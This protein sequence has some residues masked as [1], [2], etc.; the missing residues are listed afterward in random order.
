MRRRQLFFVFG[1]FHSFSI[2]SRVVD[3]YMYYQ[4]LRP[5]DPTHFLENCHVQYKFLYILNFEQMSDPSYGKFCG[6]TLSH[7]E[8]YFNGRKSNIEWYS[9]TPFAVDPTP[10]I[11]PLESVR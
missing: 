3:L 5:I 6:C 2:V 8:L 7:F 10:S 9:I 11:Y 1:H 4:H